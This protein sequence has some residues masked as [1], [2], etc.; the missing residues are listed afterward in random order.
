MNA[1]WLVDAAPPAE[2]QAASTCFEHHSAAIATFE[3]ELRGYG[4]KETT[5]PNGLKV[6]VINDDETKFLYN[7]IFVEGIY[8]EHDIDL[9]QDPVI[10]DVGANIGL[11]ALYAAKRFPTSVIYCFEPAP[12]CLAALHKNVAMLGERARIIG[13]ALG[14]SACESQFTYYP[15]HTII[16]G[17]LANA[18]RDHRTLLTSIQADYELKTG[19]LLEVRMAEML[20]AD[21]LDD[22]VMFNCQV[23]TLSSVLDLENIP[24]VALAKIDVECAEDLVLDGIEDR[25][26][27]NIDNFLIEVHD[28]GHDE[29]MRMRNRIESKGFD[30]ELHATPNL[31]SSGVYEIV[32][33]RRRT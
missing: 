8:D 15:N 22:P 27:W 32:A 28:Q 31:T 7:E 26:W 20:L 33:R 2:Q 10:L 19:K 14:A 29:P 12:P 18:E 6:T 16:S 3:L 17:F 24:R 9:G 13:A 4:M 5:L 11:F 23:R 1:H 21:K 25:H 30:A